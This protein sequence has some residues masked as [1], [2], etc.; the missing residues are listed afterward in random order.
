VVGKDNL[1]ANDDNSV[2]V[3]EEVD[4]LRD[5]GFTRP[6]VLVLCP[7]RGTALRIVHRLIRLLGGSN[8]LEGRSS[9]SGGKASVAGLERL[10]EEFSKPEE[11]EEDEDNEGITFLFN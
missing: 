8:D 1:K 3:E 7:F 2:E 11:D 10:E 5:Q 6:R 9:N 4:D